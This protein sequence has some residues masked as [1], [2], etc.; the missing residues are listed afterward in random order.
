MS[1]LTDGL[2]QL[3]ASP[4]GLV[5]GLRNQGLSWVNRLGPIKRALV[6]RALDA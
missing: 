4:H 5:R 2:L 3:F 1:E 6:A